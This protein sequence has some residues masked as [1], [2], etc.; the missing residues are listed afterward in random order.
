LLSRPEGLLLLLAAFNLES[1]PKREAGRTPDRTS[2]LAMLYLHL[3]G[4]KKKRAPKKR[5][6]REETFVEEKKLDQQN[7]KGSLFFPLWARRRRGEA[8][9][10]GFFSL[11]LLLLPLSL[12]SAAFFI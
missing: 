1:A 8:K 10:P 5:N 9:R 7:E 6:R 2:K 12:S 11:R 4:T 3:R